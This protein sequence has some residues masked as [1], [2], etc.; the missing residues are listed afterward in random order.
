MAELKEG[1]NVRMGLNY[2]QFQRGLGAVSSQC[3]SFASRI[4]KIMLTPQAA[5]AAIGIGG[6]M[7]F[8][9]ASREFAQFEERVAEIAT[10]VDTARYSMEYL[11]QTALNL[12][13]SM[14]FA[15]SDTAR[16]MYQ[17][18][19]AGRDMADMTQFMTTA[20][21][22]AQ[23]GY[24][25]LETSVMVLSKTLNAYESQNLSA[26]AAADIM[27][28][29]V[30][31]GIITMHELS[32]SLG[33][34]AT[35]AAELGIRFS[36]IQAAMAT[37]T[38]SGLNAHQAAT[39]LRSILVQI[40]SPTDDAAAY[41]RKLGLDMTT[42]GLRARGLVGTMELMAE[43]TGGSTEALAKLIP[44]I[45]AATGALILM[46]RIKTYRETFG[47]ML[48]AGGTVEEAAAKRLATIAWEEQKLAVRRKNIWI[49][50]GLN[51]RSVTREF[52]RFK[53]GA[54]NVLSHVFSKFD[55]LGRAIS[56]VQSIWHTFGSVFAMVGSWIVEGLSY[57]VDGV[58]YVVQAM[59]GGAAMIQAAWSAVQAVIGK[60][61]A[62]MLEGAA[63]VLYN[64]GKLP[65]LGHLQEQAAEIRKTRDEWRAWA[66]IKFEQRAGRWSGTLKIWN[67]ILSRT[68]DESRSA[69]EGMREFART[70][71]DV[72]LGFWRLAELDV[73]ST[74]TGGMTRIKAKIMM[75]KIRAMAEAGLPFNKI[76]EKIRQLEENY[77]DVLIEQR[78]KQWE[79]YLKFMGMADKWTAYID[80]SL[81]HETNRWMSEYRK[82]ANLA[83][84]FY[85]KLQGYE[86]ERQNNLQQAEKTLY[87]LRIQK[88]DE[89]GR[90][91]EA[92]K[93]F[94]LY[95]RRARM[96]ERAG[97][98]E[99]AKEAWRES[100][101]YLQ[102]VASSSLKKSTI[103]AQAY[104]RMQAIFQRIDQIIQH[105]EKRQRQA[106]E[107]VQKQMQ[108]LE[109][110]W[111]ALLQTF[112]QQI[113]VNIDVGKALEEVDKIR[114]ELR[115]LMK[116]FHEKII[117]VRVQFFEDV[118]GINAP[119]YKI[120]RGVPRG[121][122]QPPQPQA[123]GNT[124]APEVT[125][126]VD[127]TA[128]DMTR[129]EIR[130]YIVQELN[131]AIQRR[132]VDIEGVGRR[133]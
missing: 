22:L 96:F 58:G 49:E 69:G 97:Q 106:L 87:N 102:D 92:L 5:I 111:A 6:A 119:E 107:G 39:S 105:Q 114:K 122:F 126:N 8:R 133:A 85:N 46:S 26:A 35:T 30:Q 83:K 98:F 109:Q 71:H 79:N 21:R 20:G 113:L 82:R 124:A 16:A 112:A 12:S 72:H 66:D 2:N 90:I 25:D 63:K 89:K 14:G 81:K 11:Q 67:D 73:M 116:E 125:M 17:A 127:I 1:I 38:K 77:S 88:L 70:M 86:Q 128:P 68:G 44:N 24:I 101:G 60:V 59:K 65:K 33:R 47:Q 54:V 117:R 100:L 61:Y 84:Q 115:D 27:F 52:N 130:N 75:E 34:Y 108:Q 19:S 18:V 99:K 78:V 32:G 7:A 64:L 57:I 9:K 95:Q 110:Q 13:N 40:L 62:V 55:L 43:K 42:A 48:V 29:T 23:A 50:M 91:G 118:G 120:P 3:G 129:G 31:Y 37:L 104:A 94:Q 28:K 121:T 41:M 15:A 4:T 132:Q 56:F 93:M 103:Q 80:G 53:T 74:F 51:M 36:D 45:R 10:I 123:A 131:L 76:E